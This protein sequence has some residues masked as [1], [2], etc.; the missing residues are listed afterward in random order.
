MVFRSLLIQILT[1]F[2]EFPDPLLCLYEK[3]MT[4]GAWSLQNPSVIMAALAIVLKSMPRVYIILDGIDELANRKEASEMLGEA[5]SIKSLGLVKWFCSSRSDPELRKLFGENRNV[6]E[7]TP[8]L[9][10]TLI[11]IRRFLSVCPVTSDQPDHVREEWVEDSN[12]IFLWVSLITRILSGAG[13]TTEEEIGEELQSYPKD[14]NAFYT[15]ILGKL[16][17]RSEKERNLAR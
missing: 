6:S 16:C 5:F 7:L 13:A 12:G 17:A 2:D 8:S 10:N 4:H 11:D 1:Y 15:Q 9:E 14:L 3:E